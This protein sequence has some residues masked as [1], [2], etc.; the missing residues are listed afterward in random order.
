MKGKKKMTFR[1]EI[2]PL[3]CLPNFLRKC[4]SSVIKL[5]RCCKMAPIRILALIGSS[6]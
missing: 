6:L 1:S 3:K 2:H 4:L 5:L